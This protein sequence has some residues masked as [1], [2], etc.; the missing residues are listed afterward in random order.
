MAKM[1]ATNVMS[2]E[3]K[4]QVNGAQ[5]TCSQCPTI[6]CNKIASSSGSSINP[7][8]IAGPVVAVLVIASCAL[9]WWLRRKKRRDLARLEELA[10]RARKAESAG[11]HLSSQQGSQPGSPARS[12]RSGGSANSNTRYPTQPPAAALRASSRSP[13]PPAPVNAEYYDENG[14]TFRVYTGNGTIN[15]DPKHPDNMGS[16]PF[17]DRQSV[18]TAGSMATSSQSTNIIPIQYIPPSKSDDTLTRFFHSSQSHESGE[19]G[20]GGGGG[21]N[22]LSHAAKTLDQARQNLFRPKGHQVPQRPARAPGLD[23]RAPQS[24]SQASANAGG[25]GRL[26]PLDERSPTAAFAMGDGARDSYLS[27]NSGAPSFLSGS[28]DLYVE[29]P[30]IMTSKQVQIGRLQQAEVVQ[31]GKTGVETLGQHG[32]ARLSPSATRADANPF[33][34]GN[35]G[36]SRVSPSLSAVRPYLSINTAGSVSG[37]GSAPGSGARTLTPSTG[38]RFEGTEADYDEYEYSEPSPI[39]SGDLRFSMGSLARD[40]ISSMGTSRYLARPESGLGAVP[41]P[42]SP[43]N[44]NHAGAHGA[45]GGQVTTLPHY[46]TH[47]PRES[48]ASGKSYADSVL[49]A[50][51]MIPPGHEPVPP[52]PHSM[53]G[54]G[55]GIPQSTSMA[56]LDAH[57]HMSHMAHPTHPPPMPP[58]TSFK[59][60]G[61]P[62]RQNS[63]GPPQSRP[64]TTASVADSFL[65][66]FPFVPPNMDDMA[67]LPSATIPETASVARTGVPTAP[68]QMSSAQSIEGKKA[69]RL[70]LGMST[71]SEGLGDFDFSFD[72]DERPPMPRGSDSQA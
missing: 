70:T 35:A 3:E 12:A 53:S 14:A 64:V 66:T 8:A 1:L 45:H 30:K 31:F 18:S 22:R 60:V 44:P 65:G 26:S 4:Q 17:S 69:G 13:L 50:F 72:R 16:D 33:E 56:T 59:S 29:A 27:N 51:P 48:I 49:G 10:A 47:G 55:I 38:R 2:E 68:N 37:S 42:R 20:G 9:F 57:S 32:S 19:S 28:T 43:S 25:D 7:G 58:P 24:Q 11:F 40:S 63:N 23:L 41:S 46:A 5:M 67:E 61:P 52:L 36:P 6:V 54:F 71:T 39:S 21:D 15:L 62:R 34:Q